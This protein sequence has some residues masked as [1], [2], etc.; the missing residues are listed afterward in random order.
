MTTGRLPRAHAIA[1]GLLVVA[2]FCMAMNPV[3]GR[4]ARDLT[5][6]IGMS[7]WRWVMASLI[8]LIFA[9]P[10]LL[11]HRHQLYRNWHI[12]AVLGAL[13]MGICGAVVYIGLHHTTATNTGL[14]YAASPVL[15]LLL[16]AKFRD[17]AVSKLQLAGIPIALVGVVAIICRGDL[18]TLAALQFNPGDMLIVVASISW[19]IYSVMIKKQSLAGI[20]TITLFAAIAICGTVVQ[21]PFY[22]WESATVRPVPLELAAWSSIA[23]VAVVSSV[24]AFSFYQKGI[25]VLGPSRAGPFMYLMPVYSVLLAVTFLGETVSAYH[26]AGLVLILIGIGLATWPVRQIQHRQ[27]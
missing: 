8:L 13:G 19:A 21:L 2:P 3:I 22:L 1:Y 9:W 27:A 26:V 17:D 18:A 6:P 11:R 24:L 12:L 23:A 20:P 15:I 4:A 25:A 16:S 10:Q 14:I 5:P 7:F